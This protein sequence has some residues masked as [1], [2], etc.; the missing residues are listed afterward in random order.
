MKQYQTH[1]PSSFNCN[2]ECWDD[3]VHPVTFLAE[4]DKDDVVR[5]IIGKLEDYAKMTSS[6][7]CHI[8]NNPFI[9]NDKCENDFQ[10]S[11]LEDLH[12]G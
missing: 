9:D 12:D 1:V 7:I 5:M 6:V 10:Y 4:R 8:C 3:N 11:T 2:I